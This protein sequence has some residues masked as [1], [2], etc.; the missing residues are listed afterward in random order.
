[1][2]GYVYSQGTRVK[3][4]GN[5]SYETTKGAVKNGDECVLQDK[6]NTRGR[7]W[8]AF[9][10]NGIYFH[11]FETEV[12]PVTPAPVAGVSAEQSLQIGD[13]IRQ[14]KPAN[15][16]A[17]VGIDQIVNSQWSGGIT[18]EGNGRY[19]WDYLKENFILVRRADDPKPSHCQPD[20]AET[21]ADAPEYGDTVEY[22]GKEYKVAMSNAECKDWG[23][24]KVIMI[25]YKGGWTINGDKRE[26]MRLLKLRYGADSQMCF[27]GIENW[28]LTR[29]ADGTVIDRRPG[30]SEPVA[31]RGLME[32]A[33][34]TARQV[35]HTWPDTEKP[36]TTLIGKYYPVLKW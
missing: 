10:D 8:R 1:M 23:G 18:I 15:D 3:V 13:V 4:I 33:G 2:D 19:T 5:P 34:E 29:R 17:S 28:K 36:S 9:L 27:Y 12:S 26:F 21:V 11:I 25:E 35:V 16:P 30:M 22:M 6:L 31:M 7:E 32:F 20:R 24:G 14:I